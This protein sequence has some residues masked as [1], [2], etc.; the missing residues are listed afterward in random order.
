MS[1]EQ[2]A[3]LILLVGM[4]IVFALDRFRMEL[5]AVGGLASASRSA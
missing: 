3:I 2:A 1:F 5:V 4:L